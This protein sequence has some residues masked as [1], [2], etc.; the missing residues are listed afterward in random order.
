MTWMAICV[1]LMAAPAAV[2]EPAALAYPALWESATDAYKAKDADRAIELFREIVE[3]TPGH[4]EAW[5]GLSKAFEWA[6]RL[7]EA[8]AAGERAQ[9]VGWRYDAWPT[10]RVAQLH[11]RAGHTDLALDWLERALA[12]RFED[13]PEI[14]ADEAFAALRDNERFRR[15][16]G[17]PPPSVA[18][19][20]ERWR[21]DL[22]Y[23]VEEAQR[24]H[25]DPARP[26]FA[27]PFTDAAADLRARIPDLTDD[28]ILLGM[29]RLLA[30]LNDGHT[31]IY[32]PDADT[33]NSFNGL[34][35]PFKFYLFPEGV[36][37][38]DGVGPWA[39]HAGSRVRRLG[40]LSAEEVLERMAPYRGVDNPMTWKW[41]GPQFYL[42]SLALLRAVGATRSDRAVNVTLEAPDGTVSTLLVEGGEFDI[43]RKLRPS[44]ATEGDPPLWLSRV[45][46]N[47]WIRPLPAHRAVYFQFNQV[48]DAENESLAEVAERLRKTLKK[49]GATRLIVDVRHNNGGN[50]SLVR[51][52]V[53]VLV[54]FEM[55][56]ADRRIVVLTG[57]NTFSAAQNFVNRVEQWTDAEFAGEP[58]S[59][60][61]NFV[62]EE[63]NLLLPCSRVRGSVSSRFW[64]DSMPGDDRPWIPMDLPI[65]LRA[66]DY[67]TGRDPVLEAVLATF[68]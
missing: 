67:F 5:F 60:R 55:G 68:D 19:R 51:P 32:G 10:Y 3:R 44:P 46:D 4:G 62:G 66:A 54:E 29:M 21:F 35:L 22:A 26:A 13:R 37:V 9:N 41:M 50:N 47:Y 2:E 33:P 34:K 38:V 31:A 43:E 24:M 42:G 52:L 49:Q 17:I 59:S 56:G 36:Y 6:G 58:S 39:E 7:D 12:E 45:A 53:R 15:L 18:T 64:Q 14:A 11:A 16:A 25:A 1:L 61:P 30:I 48:R 40:E 63:T 65:E 57:R 27:G 8:I 23:L 28:E 20:D